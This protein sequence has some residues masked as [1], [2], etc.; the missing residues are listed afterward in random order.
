MK[1]K[2]DNSTLSVFINNLRCVWLLIEYERI[3]HAVFVASDQNHAVI[4]L[5]TK[6]SCSSVT[7]NALYIIEV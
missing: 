2:D 4:A 5:L 3:T 7:E 6:R 1:E